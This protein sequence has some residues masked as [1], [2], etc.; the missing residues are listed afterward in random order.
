MGPCQLLGLCGLQMGG[1]QTEAFGA[2]PSW[3]WLSF[4]GRVPAAKGRSRVCITVPRCVSGSPLVARD[5]WDDLFWPGM[6]T[7]LLL[8]P[9]RSPA[10]M[11]CFLL[12]GWLELSFTCGLGTMLAVS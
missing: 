4:K 10:T 12:R 9:F 6:G 5:I 3:P 1:R 2:C 7:P 8:V 11:H